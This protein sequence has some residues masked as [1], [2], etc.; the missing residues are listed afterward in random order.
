[1]RAVS[2]ELRQ[3][4]GALSAEWKAILETD[5]PAL[6]AKARELAPDLVVR[7]AKKGE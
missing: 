1:M 6:N 4:L 7:P 3:E 2:A 5:V